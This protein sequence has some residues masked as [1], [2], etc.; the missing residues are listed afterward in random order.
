MPEMHVI[1]YA[2]R[3]VYCEQGQI[4]ELITAELGRR[5]TPYVVEDYSGFCTSAKTILRI[6][7]D[8]WYD[9]RE[10]EQAKRDSGTWIVPPKSYTAGLDAMLWGKGC[11]HQD[12]DSCGEEI[13]DI[14]KLSPGDYGDA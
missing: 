10:S 1:N 8:N 9:L 11:K 12:E 13:H 3:A 2:E 14:T 6:H 4:K 5:T 7:R